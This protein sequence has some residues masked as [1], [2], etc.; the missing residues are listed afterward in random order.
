MVGLRKKKSKE[1]LEWERKLRLRR[2]RDTD[3]SVNENCDISSMN[4]AA[5][6]NSVM[7]VV[8]PPPV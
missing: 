4:P 6:T 5:Y 2:T 7:K 1:E 3:S 8:L